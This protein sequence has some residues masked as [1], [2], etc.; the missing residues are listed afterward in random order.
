MRACEHRAVSETRS[1]G[2]GSGRMYFRARLYDPTAGEFTSRDPLEYIDGESLTRGYMGISRQDAFGLACKLVSKVSRVSKLDSVGI[3]GGGWQ[4]SAGTNP[5]NLDG[6]IAHD[7]RCECNYT[8]S[9]LEECDA[10]CWPYNYKVLRDKFVK[11]TLG[12]RNTCCTRSVRHWNWNR[13][14]SSWFAK[15]GKFSSV[16]E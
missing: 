15:Q 4:L 16:V 8:F 12:A 5:S 1:G 2:H 11:Y 10:G 13:H 14:S 7:I 9:F 6:R 3:K